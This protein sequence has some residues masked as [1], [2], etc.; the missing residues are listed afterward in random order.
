MWKRLLFAA[1]LVHASGVVSAATGLAD[2]Y[3]SKPIRLILGYPP[4]GSDDY[5]ARIIGPKL[6]QRLSQPVIVENRPGAAGNMGAEM[7]AHA[8]PDGYTLYL[9]PSTLLAASRS[10]YPK[11][12]YDLLKDFSFISVVA[13]GGT[14]LLAHPSLPATSVSELVVLARSDPKGIPYGSAGVGSLSHLS[15]ELLQSR[16]GIELLHVAYK[17]AAPTSAALTA[18]E[19]KVAFSR[20]AAALPMIQAKRIN[21]LAVTTAKRL[22]TLPEVPTVSESGVPGFDVTITFGVLAP[23]GTPIAVVNLLN[24]EIRNI[25]QMPDVRTR[26]AAQALAAGMSTPNEYR[27][28]TEAETTQ[29]TRVIKDARIPANY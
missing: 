11:L 25:M 1:I 20:V 12:R 13:T 19:V 27:T 21:A 6:S 29:W 18:G 7:A 14:V 2:G 23:A 3:P 4:G 17:G 28:I 22:E 16:T 26:L 10:L 15:M 9:G 24:A 5:L 8:D